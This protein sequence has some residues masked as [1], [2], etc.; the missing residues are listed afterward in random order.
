[1]K[2]RT[3]EILALGVLLRLI[4]MVSSCHFD[5]LSYYWYAH[6]LVYQKSI[7][8]NLFQGTAFFRPLVYFQALWLFIIKG[9][10]NN[11]ISP[12]PQEWFNAGQYNLVNIESW[13]YFVANP[14]IQW[15]LFLLKLPYLLAEV[16]MVWFVLKMFTSA[17][18][19][20]FAL[21]FFAFNPITLFSIY[22][23]GCDDIFLALFFVLAMY[24]LINKGRIY[25]GML[26]MGFSVVLKAY[27]MIFLPIL[28][29]ILGQDFKRRLKLF[30]ISFLPI[31]LTFLI[32]SLKGT[33]F[34]SL[35]FIWRLP[36]VDYL[37]SLSI[38]FRHMEN[39][40]LIFLFFYVLLILFLA[41]EYW[42][43]NIRHSVLKFSLIALLFFYSLCFFH[44][45]YFVTIVPLVVFQIAKDRR[46]L[47][48]FVV[49]VFCYFVYILQWGK[50]LSWRLFMP[51]N[52]EFFSNLKSPV[53][54]IDV[55]F[56][57]STLFNI[58]RTIFIAVSF[59]MIY[60]LFK[61]NDTKQ[62]QDV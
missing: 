56:P 51:L 1:M 13:K 20:D 57:S 40:F 59:W 52:V 50:D 22:I 48:L 53:E 29:V 58:C 2:R 28:A 11:G 39:Q 37:F 16:I 14:Q 47:P 26:I 54:I 23:F 61:N 19:K 34:S 41:Q 12:W 36:H 4:F 17:K 15:I 33:F 60:L 8:V 10:I 21:K 35:R 49:Q 7:D 25:P 24:L 42:N 32:V 27:S 9:L 6:L 18:E 62:T 55:V 43:K 5:L 31:V 30:F 46:L 45:Q 38:P 44:P 3:F